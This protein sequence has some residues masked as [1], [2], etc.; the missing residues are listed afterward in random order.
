MNISVLGAGAW[1]TAVA[2]HLSRMAEHRTTLVPRRIEQALTMAS[3]REN[4]EYLPGYTLGQDLQIG[5]ELKPAL[6]EAD[7]IVLACPSK[8]LRQLCEQVKAELESSWRI[9]M[10]ITLCKGLEQA[11]LL[12]PAEVVAAILPE[13]QHAVLSGPTFAGEV[14]AGQPTAMVLA[15]SGDDC[16]LREVQG[17]LNNDALR[18]YRSNDVVGVELGGCLKNV[19]AI[20]AGMCDG[21]KTGDNSKAAF[22]TRAMHEMVVIGQSQGARVETLYGLS[23]FGDL[24]ATCHGSWS[25]NR[26]FGEQL[27]GGI[28]VDDLLNNRKTVVEGYWATACFHELCQKHAI[29]API[30]NQIYAIA[31]EHKDPRQS[32]QALMTRDLKAEGS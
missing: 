19:Y 3:T 15:S 2:L 8:G 7:V 16:L 1:G 31:Y 13:M 18:V 10:V 6:M 24:V 23:G 26:T 28:A 29:E 27:A 21:L 25:R 9:K 4:Q 20:G 22:L 17:A 5:C 30:L 32:L 11:T 14:A 12:K